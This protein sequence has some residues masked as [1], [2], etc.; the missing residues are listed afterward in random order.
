MQRIYVCTNMRLAS[1]QPSCA[2]RGS[3][4]LIERLEAGIQ[5]RHLPYE[6]KE[7]VC[8][9][10]CAKGPNVKLAGQAFKHG[11]SADDV[12]QFLGGLE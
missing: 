9:G 7:S 1:D 5:A 3:R 11:F 2:A 10:H 6:V 4:D 12:E 8:F